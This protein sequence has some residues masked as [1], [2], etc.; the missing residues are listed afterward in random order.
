MNGLGQFRKVIFKVCERR[1]ELADLPILCDTRTQDFSTFRQVSLLP[2][3]H[4][5]SAQAPRQYIATTSRSYLSNQR[6]HPTSVIPVRFMIFIRFVNAR[7]R[8]TQGRPMEKTPLTRQS[9]LLKALHT[10][11]FHTIY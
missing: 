10:I 2:F 3:D 9:Q 8:K 7:D 11:P 6:H 5:S 4:Y 1:G